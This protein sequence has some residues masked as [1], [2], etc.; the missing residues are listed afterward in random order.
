MK[1][2][3]IAM[4][5]LA[6]A[7][8]ALVIYAGNLKDDYQQTLENYQSECVAL[9][10]KAQ[11]LAEKQAHLEQLL[12]QEAEQQIYEA[13]LKVSIEQ[14]QQ[15]LQQIEDEKTQVKADT[16]KLLQ[17]IADIRADQTGESDEAYYLEV[18]DALTEGL[19]KVKEYLAGN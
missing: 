7:L 2:K 3:L 5:L 18:Y 13:D 12:E 17:E 1:I 10:A 9:E 16:E 15:Q 14:L 8:A 11:E 6:A 19:N 4:V